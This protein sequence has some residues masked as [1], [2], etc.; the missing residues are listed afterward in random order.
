MYGLLSEGET[1]LYAAGKDGN[2]QARILLKDDGS[3]NFVTTDTNTKDGKTLLMRIA[4]DGIQITTPW[5]GLVLNQDGWS[6]YT[7][8]GTSMP[9]SLQ[10][11]KSGSIA[12]IGNKFQC[13][14]SN[15]ALGLAPSSVTPAAY[16]PPGSPTAV[17]SLSVFVSP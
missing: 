16:M 17:P 14:T 6:L 10:L 12:P 3:I 8:D 7:Q 15:V 4:S 5:G 2:S 13:M 9:C 1:C 11:T